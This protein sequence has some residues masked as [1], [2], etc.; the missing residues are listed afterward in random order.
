MNPYRTVLEA[1]IL[2]LNYTRNWHWLV[3]SNHDDGVHSAAPSPDRPSQHVWWQ[4]QVSILTRAPYE[5]TLC[6][7]TA[8]VWHR[9]HDSNVRRLA[10]DLRF[11]GGS[12]EPLPHPGKLVAPEGF[13]PSPSD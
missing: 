10:A 7:G 13:D 5:S 4:H 9:E 1:G 8:A 3:E 2:P 12:V 11:K 6:A